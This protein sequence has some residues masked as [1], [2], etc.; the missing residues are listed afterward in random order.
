MSRSTNRNYKKGQPHR[1]FRKFI[2]VAEG[3][4][5]DDYFSYFQGLNKRVSVQIVERI[6]GQS[7]V[8]FMIDRLDIYNY[9]NGIE[10]E[11]FVWFVIDVDRWRRSDIDDLNQFCDHEDNWNLSISNICFEVWL[12]YH[13]TDE[14]PF[15]LDTARKLKKTLNDLIP[16]GYNRD[17]FARLIR[18]AAENSRNA[19]P[20]PE[21]FFP[22]RHV[23]KVYTLA[24]RL[25]EFLGN[26]W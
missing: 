16:G 2:I 5:E 11:D 1:D 9:K 7:A 4:R 22:I 25:L 24:D 19:D 23:T 6:A 15:H 12:Y 3:E 10:V 26:N 20:H 13:I 14:I 18:T 21:H 8:K 17:Y